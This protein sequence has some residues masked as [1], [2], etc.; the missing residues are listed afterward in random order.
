MAVIKCWSCG[1]KNR[2][3]EGAAARLQP[4][5]GRCGA[6]LNANAGAADAG[7]PRTVTDAT[8]TREVLE[9]R[10]VPVLLD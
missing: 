9:V 6:A 8:F 1:A 5:C 2:V 7:K 3:D 10:G 4:V